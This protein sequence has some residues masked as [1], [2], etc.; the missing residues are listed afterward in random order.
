M[1]A[2]RS[3]RYFREE[4]ELEFF[5]RIDGQVKIRGYRIELPEIEAVLLENKEIGSAVMIQNHTM[6]LG[7]E[8]MGDRLKTK[9]ISE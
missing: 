7:S 1:I 8:P 9:F 6:G 2:P 3:T 4:D 5:G